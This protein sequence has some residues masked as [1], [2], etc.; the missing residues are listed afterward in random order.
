MCRSP[1]GVHRYEKNHVDYK[2]FINRHPIH[3]RWHFPNILPSPS[4]TFCLTPQCYNL[5]ENVYNLSLH[6]IIHN[7]FDYITC[8]KHCLTAYV[9]AGTH[10]HD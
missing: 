4:D 3:N 2:T 7:T 9:S 10:I 8:I 5:S 6:H 1:I